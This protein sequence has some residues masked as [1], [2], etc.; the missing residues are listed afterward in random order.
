MLYF[1]FRSKKTNK[2]EKKKPKVKVSLSMDKKVKMLLEMNIIDS[3]VPLETSIGRIGHNWRNTW[4]GYNTSIKWPLKK[5][6]TKQEA[7]R[8]C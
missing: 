3:K 1:I 4:Q 7:I 8:G 5:K 2:K 6:D